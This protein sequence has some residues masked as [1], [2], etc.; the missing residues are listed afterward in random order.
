[1]LKPVLSLLLAAAALAAGPALAQQADDPAAMRSAMPQKV[2]LTPEVVKRT[3]DAMEELRAK[4][5]M[6][7]RSKIDL[8]QSEIKAILKEAARKHGFDS[9][10][11]LAAN[12]SSTM[13]AFSAVMMQ[14]QVGDS[15]QSRGQYE[16]QRA[17]IE[18]SPDISAERKQQMLKMMEMQRDA[19]KA[20]AQDE[21]VDVVRPYAPRIKAMFVSE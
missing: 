10:E 6:R 18:N 21:N 15:D 3:V 12:V 1:M 20:L 7:E 17:Q 19:L 5:L 14:E 8:P 9:P 11:D 13:Q 2:A 4:G 16:Q